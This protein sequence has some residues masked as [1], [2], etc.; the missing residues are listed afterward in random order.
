L[1][2]RAGV[3]D[4]HVEI[5]LSNTA[6]LHVNVVVIV[7]VDKLEVLHGGLI[8]TSVEVEHKRLH[9]FVPLGWLVKEEHYSLSIILLE[10]LLQ[11]LGS[12][13]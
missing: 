3:C 4:V 6:E 2:E 13:S 10:L 11:R 8:D 9:L 12:V 5:L 7:L 1:E